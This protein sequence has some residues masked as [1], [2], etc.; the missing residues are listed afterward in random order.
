MLGLMDVLVR[1]IWRGTKPG[2]AD[3]NYKGTPAAKARALSQQ[4]RDD[5][6]N[7]EGELW[8]ISG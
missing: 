7:N 4:E 5:G 1:L 2:G 8:L 3:T 6:G